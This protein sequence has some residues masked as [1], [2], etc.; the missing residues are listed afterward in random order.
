METIL[1]NGNIYTMDKRLFKATAVKIKGNRITEVGMDDLIKHKNNYTKLINLNGKTLVPGFC[2]GH[3]HLLSFGYSLEMAD[4]NNSISIQDIIETVKKHIKKY[5]IKQ[6][7]WIE[8]RGWNENNFINKTMP[9]RYDLDRISNT[10]PIVL[11]R[12]CGQVCVCNTKAL[13]YLNLNDFEGIKIDRDNIELDKNGVP[14]GII[15]GNAMKLVFE[16]IPKLGKERIKKLIV[17]ASQECLNFGITSVDTD[18]FELIRA[19]DFNDI[20]DAYFELDYEKKLPIRIN[21]M[22]Y[23]PS[24]GL[25]ESFIKLGYKTGYG[26]DFFKIGAFKLQTD[27]SLGAKTAALCEPYI[28]DN[29]NKG[30]TLMSQQKINELVEIAHNNGLQVVMD[31]IGDRAMKMAILAYKKIYE[32]NENNNDLRFGIDHC[33]ITTKEIIAEFKKYN[34]IAGSDIPVEPVNP[35]LGIYSAVTR[36]QI[37][38][39]P[40][41]GWIPEQKLTVYEAVYAYTMGTAYSCFEE[42]IRGSITEGKYADFVI[43][44]D[45]IFKISPEKIKDV[46]VEATIINGKL[47]YGEI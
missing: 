1:Y 7:E 5:R 21:K 35:I 38:G 16:K 9:N 20:L 19:G 8:G 40:K 43:L 36:Q 22:L 28:G 42:D 24:K 13:Q 23:L 31:A 4:L 15:K 41:G 44:S 34:I 29:N 37:N 12:T 6:N 14:T 17:K 30:I 18:D 26:S 3:T 45:N 10:N 27:G 32:K 11:I 47:V 33:Q 46:F 2:D 39:V 25:L